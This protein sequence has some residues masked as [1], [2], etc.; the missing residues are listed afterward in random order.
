MTQLSGPEMKHVQPPT[1]AVTDLNFESALLP[2]QCLVETVAKQ[3][4]PYPYHTFYRKFHVWSP[5]AKKK[6]LSRSDFLKVF[7]IVE[8]DV[9]L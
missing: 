8:A 3:P 5:A 1:Q 2:Y 6:T 7:I 9:V 4:L